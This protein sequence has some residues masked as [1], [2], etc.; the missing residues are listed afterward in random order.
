MPATHNNVMRQLCNLLHEMTPRACIKSFQPFLFTHWCNTLRMDV[1]FAQ[2]TLY[3]HLTLWWRKCKLV[4]SAH[5]RVPSKRVAMVSR[6]VFCGASRPLITGILVRVDCVLLPPLRPAEAVDSWSAPNPG[7]NRDVP[8]AHPR[9]CRS[10]PIRDT[11]GSTLAAQQWPYPSTESPHICLTS[12]HKESENPRTCLSKS[13]AWWWDEPVRNGSAGDR[14]S[15]WWS[16][17]ALMMPCELLCATLHLYYWRSVV[18]ITSR[19][20]V[21]WW[22]ES[23]GEART[24]VPAH[25]LFIIYGRFFVKMK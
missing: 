6:K 22:A 9:P 4:R 24:L 18:A 8:G 19:C 5:L 20:H 16:D 25:C 21:T 23:G 17:C 15:V 3:L 7:K 13:G 1:K 10:A 14:S 12:C 11:R 2:N